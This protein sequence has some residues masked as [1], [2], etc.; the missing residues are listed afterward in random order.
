MQ[1]RLRS[2]DANLNHG[3]EIVYAGKLPEAQILSDVP[4]EGFEDVETRGRVIDGHWANILVHGDNLKALKILCRM[5]S[6]R[7][8]VRLIYID[9]P[10]STRQVYRGSEDRWVT[11]SKSRNDKKAY[12]DLLVGPAFLEFLRQRLILLREILA[13]NGSIYVHIDTKVGHY[14]KVLMDEVFGRDRFINDI[15]RVKC[16]PKNFERKAYGNIKDMILFYAKGE[17]TIWNDPREELTSED[18]KRLFPKIDAQGR[19]YTTT[20]LHAPGETADG[21]TGS[22][23]KGLLPPK[24]RH[25]RQ[26]P[27]ELDRLDQMGLIEWSS[28]GNPRKKIFADEVLAKGKKM[29]DIWEFKDP[30][31]PKYPTEKNSELLRMIVETSSNPG[32]LVLDCFCGSGT[33]LAAAEDLGRH[34]IGIDQSEFAISA[35][36]KR[37]TSVECHAPFKIVAISEGRLKKRNVGHKRKS[38]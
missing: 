11:V 20:P 36:K 8:K 31:Y 33:T 22:P 28:T 34:W 25:W 4:L 13:L 27:S 3:I 30:A 24:G 23:W 15:T 32:D 12:E 37:I 18:I 5:R 35:T 19:R 17:K 10:F 16:N 26:K 14:V 6:I 38:S 1:L 2:F 29:Q 21:P 7:G 9:P